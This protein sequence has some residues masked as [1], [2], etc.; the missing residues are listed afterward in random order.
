[1]VKLKHNLI[2]PHV[3]QVEYWQKITSCVQYLNEHPLRSSSHQTNHWACAPTIVTFILNDFLMKFNINSLVYTQ[4][5]YKYC[6][7]MF[8]SIL[9]SIVLL[10]S[11]SSAVYL[12]P[13]CLAR[14]GEW[15]W[16]REWI[17]HWRFNLH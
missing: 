16:C 14:C 7:C 5:T 1:M 10:K 9:E 15:I 13:N 11:C 4:R 6:L 8:Y 2:P 3:L 12:M 17:L